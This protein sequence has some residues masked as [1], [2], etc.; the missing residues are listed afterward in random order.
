MKILII[1]ADGQLGSDLCR[2]IPAE[3]QIPLT[4]KE[5]DITDREQS[6]KVIHKYQPHIVINTAA[7]HRVDDCEEKVSEAFAVN[8]VGVKM[9]AEACREIDSALLH[10]ST[11]YV[12]DGSKRTPYIETD[13]P[14]PQSVYGISKLAGELIL[15][16]MLEKYFIV[17]TTGLYG[18]AGCLGKGGGNF[19]ENMIKRAEAQ[20]ELRVVNDEILSPTYTADLARKIYELIRTRH[21]GLYHIVNRGACSWYEFTV[22]IFELM[23]KKVKVVP[24]SAKEY[25]TKA[26]RPAYSVMANSNLATLGLDDMR[27]WKEALRAYLTEKGRVTAQ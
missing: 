13:I 25:K 14:A 3:E 24:V 20:N 27:D 17:R 23:N 26:R 1:G 9:V 16:Y 10:I 15:R 22:K 19:V 5:L 12:F 4:I 6:R 2:V 8:S 7:Y 21:Y 11:D 18:V